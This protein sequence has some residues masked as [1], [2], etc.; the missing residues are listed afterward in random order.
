MLEGLEGI[1][2]R[3]NENYVLVKA[4]FFTFGL[5]CPISTVERLKVGEHCDFLIYMSFPQ[6][7]APELFGFL[8]DE[9]YEVFSAL[10][11]V[12]KIGPKLALKILSGTKP[13]TLKSLIA[14]R[15]LE[16]L[17]HLPGLGK[18]TAERLIAEIGHLFEGEFES[19]TSEMKDPRVEDAVN[20]LVSLGFDR[21]L[22]LKTISKVMKEFPDLDTSE[23]IKESLKKIR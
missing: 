4:G 21:R 2:K 12:N 7:K 20:A 6:D 14:T 5:N 15:N 8:T 23:L 16:G 22:T 18:K 17:S 10:I 9:E 11:K 1:V 19:G 13:N 3:I